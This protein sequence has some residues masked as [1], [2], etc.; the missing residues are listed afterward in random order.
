MIWEESFLLKKVMIS[1]SLYC[2]LGISEFC[3]VFLNQLEMI[4]ARITIP[5]MLI[6]NIL[7]VSWEIC[8]IQRII[9]GRT[10]RA[11]RN[12]RMLLMFISM[13]ARWRMNQL[14]SNE[15]CEGFAV[16]LSTWP[17][18]AKGEWRVSSWLAISTYVKKY[19]IFSRVLLRLFSAPEI[20]V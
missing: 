18:D 7:A 20:L 8:N 3:Q 1:Q 15:N 12:S 17:S 13:N 9:H 19:V 6:T 10:F 2:P 14:L 4:W 5:V 16:Y 11:L